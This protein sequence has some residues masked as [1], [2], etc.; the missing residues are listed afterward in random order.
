[1]SIS[2]KKRYTQFPPLQCFLWGCSLHVNIHMIS[3]F[4]L[5][6]V[7]LLLYSKRYG[8]SIR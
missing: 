7:V 8:N 3:H 1:M 2:A 6:F 4:G 5:R